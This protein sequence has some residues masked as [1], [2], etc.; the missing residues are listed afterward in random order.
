MELKDVKLI[1]SFGCYIIQKTRKADTMAFRVSV[2]LL[3]GSK[4]I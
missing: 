3:E 4:Y 2:F 1:S